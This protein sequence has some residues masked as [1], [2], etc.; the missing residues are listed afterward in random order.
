M[1]KREERVIS[2]TDFTIFLKHSYGELRTHTLCV[3]NRYNN[4]NVEKGFMLIIEFSEKFGIPCD[5]KV[6][7]VFMVA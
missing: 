7:I 5:F 6:R 3:K 4:G 1:K 2:K